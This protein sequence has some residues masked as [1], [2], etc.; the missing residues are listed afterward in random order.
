VTNLADEVDE[1]SLLEIFSDLSVDS[2]KV[3]RNR[4]KNSRA[5]VNFQNP[6]SAVE[7]CRLD[8]TVVSGKAMKVNLKHH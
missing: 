2:C 6:K 8:G 7:A 1:D 4:G 3:V 5:F